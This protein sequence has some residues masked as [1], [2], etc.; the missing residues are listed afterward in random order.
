MKAP[1]VKASSLLCAS[2]YSTTE[3][4]EQVVSS[5]ALFQVPLN[6]NGNCG[7][8]LGV[9]TEVTHCYHFVLASQKKTHS[10]H[11]SF[12]YLYFLYKQTLRLSLLRQL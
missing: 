2:L 1:E 12:L 6:T 3:V 10:L 8:L 11:I 5:F 4:S 9:R 7:Q